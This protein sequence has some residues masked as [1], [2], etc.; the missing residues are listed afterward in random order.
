MRTAIS[1][2]TLLVLASGPLPAQSHKPRV[3]AQGDPLPDAA[4]ARLGTLRFVHLGGLK[5]VA[6]SPDGKMAASGVSKG[7]SYY[8]GHAVYTESGAVDHTRGEW[9][10]RTTIRLWDTATG[11]CLRE[12]ATPDAP[13]HALQFDATGRFL[14]AGCNRYM[15]C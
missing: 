10:T 14:I 5:S 3:D 15:C 8:T 12:I 2:C 9:L 13:V 1:L 4:I 7:E 11:R 6:V